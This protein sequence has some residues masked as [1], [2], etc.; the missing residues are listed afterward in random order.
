MRKKAENRTRINRPR[1]AQRGFSMVELTVVVA[2]ISI[3]SA[4]AVLELPAT[5]QTIRADTALRQVVDQ[6][7]QAREYSIANRRYVQVT[8]GVVGGLP[9]I[10]MIQRNDLTAGAGA[11]NP[12][13]STV[14]L[15]A[16]MTFLVF[17]GLPDTPD[18]FGNAAAVDFEGVNGG[19]PGGMLF[20]SDGE[21]VD[22]GTVVVGGS[23]TPINGSVFLG[24][25]VASTARAA[26]VMGTTGRVHG[27]TSGGTAWNQF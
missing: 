16:P 3:I 14:T 9:Q 21:L 25:A 24:G 10:Q 22:G 15:Q 17:G 7:R 20:Q 4:F 8:F 26:T 1:R 11:A 18:L 12:I 13:L 23:G 6:L 27:W 5:M 19:P 2:L